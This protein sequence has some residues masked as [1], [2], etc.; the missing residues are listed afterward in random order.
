ME[1]QVASTFIGNNVV[2]CI[3]VYLS[4]LKPKSDQVTSSLKL[5]SFPIP[6]G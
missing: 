2:T 5:N 6:V 3:G 4:H 1:T